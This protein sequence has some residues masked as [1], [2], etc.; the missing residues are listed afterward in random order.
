MARKT[1]RKHRDNKA[2]KARRAKPV[3]AKPATV[4]L[5]SSSLLPVVDLR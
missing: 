3:K 4:T 2:R 5:P 1:K